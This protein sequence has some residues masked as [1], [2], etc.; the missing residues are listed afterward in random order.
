MDPGLSRRITFDGLP[1][2]I[3]ITVIQAYITEYISG[4]PY[5]SVERLLPLMVVSQAWMHKIAGTPSLWTDIIVCRYKEDLEMKVSYAVH[6]SMETK[7]S[8]YFLEF[9]DA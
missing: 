4:Y 1:E 9:T 7:L 6:L 5:L 3:W 8:I 2:E